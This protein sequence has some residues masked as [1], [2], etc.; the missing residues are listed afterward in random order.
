M[1]KLET[2]KMKKIYFG[3]EADGDIDSFFLEHS[4]HVHNYSSG[5]HNLSVDGTGVDPSVTQETAEGIA[6]YILEKFNCEQELTV[7]DI[8]TGLGHMVNGFNNNGIDGFGIEGSLQAASKSVCPKGRIT[9]LDMS[10][11]IEDERLNKCCHLTT[12]FELLEHIHRNHEDQFLRNLAYL[13]DFHLCSINMDE[14]PGTA[15]NHCNIKHLCCWLE[16]FRKHGIGYEILGE[17]TKGGVVAKYKDDV[18]VPSYSK[19]THNEEFR[20]ATGCDWHFSTF[21]L[22]DFSESTL[23]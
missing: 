9:L 18:G 3:G 4:I 10:V 19:K 1:P 20:E 13:S 12:S 15:A 21:I 6:K 23:V 7:L 8:G 11:N 17:A 16:L 2:C 22:L 5:Q 14:W